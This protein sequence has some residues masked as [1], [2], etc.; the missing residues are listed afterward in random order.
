MIEQLQRLLFAVASAAQL[1][2]RANSAEIATAEHNPVNIALRQQLAT[3]G[4][5]AAG[6]I[7]PE[8]R[9]LPTARPAVLLRAVEYQGVVGRAALC[10]Q[11]TA[12]DRKLL[13]VG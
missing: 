7:G 5:L 4:Q 3:S 8:F 13:P 9:D 10:G 11:D 1:G 12:P 2:R 6:V